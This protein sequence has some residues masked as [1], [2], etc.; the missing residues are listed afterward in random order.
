ML[1][2]RLLLMGAMASAFAIS[3]CR[4]AEDSAWEMKRQEALNRPRRIL[5]ND[6]GCD[7]YY[8]DKGVPVTVENARKRIN[9]SAP[10]ELAE[11]KADTLI[12]N[13]LA[14]GFC[15]LI[16]D[17]KCGDLLTTPPAPETGK[18][19]SAF[20]ALL[21]QGT[22]YLKLGEE[23]SRACGKE[24]FASMRM[25]DVHDAYWPDGKKHFLFPKFKEDHP[26]YLFGSP[27]KSLPH[28]CW[29][30]VDY[31]EPEVRERMKG[32]LREFCEN[33]D[34]D[35]LEYDFTRDPMLLK[36]VAKTGYASQADCDFITDYMA[37]LREMT[38]TI[39]RRRGRPILIAIRVPNA[40]D[41]C[42]AAGLDVE[43]WFRRKLADI[44]VADN[45]LK[46]DSYDASFK[47]PRQY[48]AKCYAAVDNICTAER[49]DGK[50]SADWHPGAIGEALASSADGV[51]YFNCFGP[52]V[53]VRLTADLADVYGK[54]KF[55]IANSDWEGSR[56]MSFIR[57][58]YKYSKRPMVN[59]NIP[60]ALKPDVPLTVTFDLIDDMKDPA[61]LARHPK[62]WAE[63]YGNVGSDYRFAL[64]VNG[65]A[66][67][68]ST[69]EKGHF[70]FDI[71]LDALRTGTNAF[72]VT[73]K[74]MAAA[75]ERELVIMK[76]DKLLKGADQPPWRRVM[77]HGNSEIEERIEDNAYV[78]DDQ[79]AVENHAPNMLYPLGAL[80][81]GDMELA[82]QMK[83][84]RAGEPDATMLRI[85]N[86]E[87]VEVIQFVK[88]GIVLKASGTKVLCPTMDAFHDYLLQLNG[89]RLVLSQ[90]GRRL[91]EVELNLKVGDPGSKI[92]E[93]VE[94]VERMHEKSL[95]IGSMSGLG[96]GASAWRNLM[97]HGSVIALLNEFNVSLRF[98]TESASD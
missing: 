3:S 14:C 61:L 25:N 6:D 96:T 9:W 38:E 94:A 70:H 64:S 77:R 57:D 81:D 67:V 31:G 63:L 66:P 23:F 48:G 60:Y 88:D 74:D 55:Y 17:T 49:K 69:F 1:R 79:T 30:M 82:F 20:P 62:A 93:A 85:A 56:L 27:T 90:D 51:Y 18:Y 36:S 33:Y 35:G 39:G 28:G 4:L 92:E 29:S 75:T 84:L 47:V 34:I 37:E 65:S 76:G 8:W 21:E 26:E 54:D 95:M 32:C 16:T 68:T 53:K 42:R 73:L 44:M 11:S 80:T 78:F 10:T 50:Q 15:N 13:P 2:E 91:L 59:H 72:T 52:I 87:V 71:P 98:D 45:W 40:P 58:G 41:Y 24:F 89:K 12:F 5:W 22:D 43:E 19:I 7:I 86:G 83:L 46:M 97:L